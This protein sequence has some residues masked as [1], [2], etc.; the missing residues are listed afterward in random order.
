VEESNRNAP[1]WVT[2]LL[3]VIGVLCLVAAVVYLTKPASQLPSFFPGHD[4]A[5]HGKHFK[6]GLAAI[7]V[8]VIAF[9]GAWLTTGHRRS[10]DS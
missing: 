3:V 1:V 9:I 10:V 8:A 7:G 5:V 6:H 4:A 2:W